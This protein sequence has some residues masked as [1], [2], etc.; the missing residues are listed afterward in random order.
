MKNFFMWSEDLDLEKSIYRVIL[1]GV[2]IVAFLMAGFDYYYYSAE[3]AFLEF[4]FGAVSVALLYCTDSHRIEYAFSSR[5]FIF[6]MALPIYWNLLYNESVIESTILFIFLPIIT[7][8]LRPFKEMLF[9]VILFGISFLYICYSNTAMV[10]FT[11]MEMF[12]LITMQVLMSFFVV[13]YVQTNKNYKDVIYKQSIALQDANTRLEELYK[14]KEIEAYTDSL[15]GLNNRA[16][17]MNQLEYLYARYKREKET[18]SFILFDIDKFKTVNDTFGHQKGDEV[19]KKIAQ[20]ALKSIR[21]VDTA[22]RYGGEEFVVLLPQTN[23]VLAAEIAERIRAEM[24][25]MIKLDG[26][27]VTASFGV[28]KIEENMSIAELIKL[29]DKALYE[30]K[31]AGRNQVMCA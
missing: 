11:Y 25:E 2:S 26:K 31:A 21:E 18:F 17:M 12:K 30:A 4:S 16:A 9:F 5:I 15:T 22:A 20:V 29:A 28:V 10:E 23:A 3:L 1:K 27:G 19:L 8:I 14:E 7:I 6:F 24:Q 13:T